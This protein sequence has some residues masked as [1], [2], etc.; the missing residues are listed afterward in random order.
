MNRGGR[1]MKQAKPIVHCIY[2]NSE[3]GLNAIVEES[4]RLYLIRMLETPDK[5]MVRYKQ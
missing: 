5:P 2:A 1:F 3:K 4:F